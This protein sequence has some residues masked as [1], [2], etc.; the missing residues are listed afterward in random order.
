[1]DAVGKIKNFASAQNRT[2]VV[3]PIAHLYTG[4]V[5]PIPYIYIHLKQF[6]SMFMNYVH[7]TKDLKFSYWCSEKIF[8]GLVRTKFHMPTLYISLVLA[9]NRKVNRAVAWL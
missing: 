4:R 7:I 5:I 9:T 6:V 8:W 2:G 3:Q 1:L